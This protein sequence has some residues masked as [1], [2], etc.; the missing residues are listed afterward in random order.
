MQ[1]GRPI[2]KA[3]R[4]WG[5]HNVH[6]SAQVQGPES[7]SMRLDGNNLPWRDPGLRIC[8]AQPAQVKHSP[9]FERTL[10][11]LKMCLAA[12]QECAQVVLSEAARKPAGFG[13]GGQRQKA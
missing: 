5:I 4:D 7:K 10:C 9:G 12:A 1:L 6:D 2:D 13:F 3:K 11:S 8:D